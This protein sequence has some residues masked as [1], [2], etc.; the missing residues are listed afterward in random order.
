MKNPLLC[1][2]EKA[3]FRDLIPMNKL[4]YQQSFR[5]RLEE[6]DIDGAFSH[7]H[8]LFGDGGLQLGGA[9][10]IQ[11]YGPGYFIAIHPSFLPYVQIGAEYCAALKPYIENEGY[12]VS[13][14]K[15]SNSEYAVHISTNLS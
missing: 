8:S 10:A 11:A 4:I 15:T 5:S 9:A 12:P 13:N 6:F 14:V 2:F 7:H 3:F 1:L